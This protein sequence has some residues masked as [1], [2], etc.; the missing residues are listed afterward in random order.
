MNEEISVTL[1]ANAGLLIQGK[2]RR[3]LI[4]GLHHD[5]NQPFSI[6]SKKKL[7]EVIDGSEEYKDVEYIMYTHCHSDHFSGK[8]TKAYLE[9]NRIETLFLPHM[10]KDKERDTELESYLLGEDIHQM[11]LHGD[12]GELRTYKISGEVR[13]HAFKAIHMGEEYKEEPH[14]CIVLGIGSHNILILGDA[15]Y[16]INTFKKAL[17][18]LSI[19]VMIINP[20]FFNHKSGRQ[21]M[22]DLIR[23][24][25]I[26]IYHIPFEEDDV[27]G[28]CRL[29]KRDME[30]YQ[31]VFPK[32]HA[33]TE[34][35]QMIHLYS[36][37]V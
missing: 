35:N 13:I 26:I 29:T 30:K 11:K 17:S 31:G 20:L 9:R 24:E 7:N 37:E 15:D 16:D 12:V 25:E 27:Y 34:E 1:I 21:I 32:V 14:Y 28:I 10:G 22:T 5:E 3:F 6:A 23:P 4:D 36:D 18:G 19:H 2:S 33:L 8:H